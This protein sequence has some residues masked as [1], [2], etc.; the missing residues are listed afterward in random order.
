MTGAPDPFTHDA[1][2]NAGAK[3]SPLA[4][5]EVAGE[6]EASALSA[7]PLQPLEALAAQV[8][9]LCYCL[10]DHDAFERE[11]APLLRL[12]VGR[13]DGGLFAAWVH[14]NLDRLKH[15]ERFTFL[16][17]EDFDEEF[18]EFDVTEYARF[19]LTAFCEP[20]TL[21][22]MG[23]AVPALHR[24][25][26]RFGS[27]GH[28]PAHLLLGEPVTHDGTTRLSLSTGAHVGLLPAGEPV[29][30]AL[31]AARQTLASLREPGASG[32]LLA[33]PASPKQNGEHDTSGNGNELVSQRYLSTKALRR[34]L[35]QWVEVL[36]EAHEYRV[37]LLCLYDLTSRESTA[38]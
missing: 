23:H 4:L 12:A 15:P 5:P 17:E 6:A 19:A 27:D 25:L 36:E 24:A 34:V 7:A 16:Y 29:D 10:F 33:A 35:T 13:Q 3:A 38:S 11:L 14:V 31:N 9:E 1:E 32:R 30:R 26:T 22:R 37:G 18:R 2:V 20:E 28:D 21:R 8:N